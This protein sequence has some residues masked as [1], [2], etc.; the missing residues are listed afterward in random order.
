[1]TMKSSQWPPTALT[2]STSQTRPV[3]TSIRTGVCLYRA[4]LRGLPD[5]LDLRDR[6]GHRDL[7][8]NPERPA[9]LA[10]KDLPDLRDRPDR[11]ALRGV[12]RGRR[13]SDSSTTRIRPVSSLQI[14]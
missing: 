6:L 10:P 4:D 2:R 12:K 3:K 13:S 14:R 5:P 1:A 9:L 11:R 7:R 8:E